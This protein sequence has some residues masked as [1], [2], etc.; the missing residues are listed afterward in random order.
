T[1]GFTSRTKNEH[2]QWGLLRNLQENTSEFYIFRVAKAPIERRVSWN[3]IQR[4]WLEV[5]LHASRTRPSRSSSL[6]VL[7]DCLRLYGQAMESLDTHNC[8]LS[9]WQ[10]AESLTRSEDSGGQT[11]QVINRLSWHADTY[12]TTRGLELSN[13]IEELQESG[14]TL[15]ITA[16][17]GY[18][19]WT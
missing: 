14:T 7:S 13:S 19:I 2:P 5:L 15:F 6:N 9:L 8:Y 16:F 4:H 12:R 11:R 3:R 17:I 10:A 1:S 18:R